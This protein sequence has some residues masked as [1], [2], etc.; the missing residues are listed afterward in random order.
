MGQN[1]HGYPGEMPEPQQD[2]PRRKTHRARTAAII[3]GAAIAGIIAIAVAA[4]GSNPKPTAVTAPAATH[5]ASQ[6]AAPAHPQA[7]APSPDGTYQGACNYTLGN[8][9]VGGTAVATGDVQVMNTGNIGTIV[10]V[11]ISWPQQGYSPLSMTKTVQ[12]PSG[13]TNDVQFHRP[14]SQDQLSNLQNW[15]TGHG[16]SDGC[17]YDA[18]ITGTYGTVQGS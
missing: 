7:A 8:D 1:Y 18:T 14:L 12:V 6:A 15:Q 17:T 2:P 16:F 9:P 5:S 13:Q 4:G 11:S 10:K 3:S